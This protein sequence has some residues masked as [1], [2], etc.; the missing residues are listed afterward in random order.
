MRTEKNSRELR[1]IAGA[2]TSESFR[3]RPRSGAGPAGRCVAFATTAATTAPGADA[4]RI[5]DAPACNRRRTD[6]PDPIARTRSPPFGGL[7]LSGI[8]I[9]RP[10]STR[11]GHDLNYDSRGAEANPGRPLRPAPFKSTG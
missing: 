5:T 7:A 11:A 6:E 1:A 2:F 4:L 10:D 8:L 9:D 3:Q